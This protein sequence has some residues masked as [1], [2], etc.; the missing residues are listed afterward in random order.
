[1]NWAAIIC[2]GIL[3][4]VIGLWVGGQLEA[5]KWRAK[6]ASGIRMLNHGTMYYVVTESTM[7]EVIRTGLPP[8]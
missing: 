4:G 8:K 3:G 7:A 1:M 6:A 5:A 2:A